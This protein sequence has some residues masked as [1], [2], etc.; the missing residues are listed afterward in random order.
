M[1]ELTYNQGK[2]IL[3][4]KA[5]ISITIF[6]LAMMLNRNGHSKIYFSCS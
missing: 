6:Q 3:L 4:K 5:A 2:P 1:E